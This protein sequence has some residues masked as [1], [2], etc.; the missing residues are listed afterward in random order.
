MSESKGISRRDFLKVGSVLGATAAVG[1]TRLLFPHEADAQT[2]LFSFMQRKYATIDEMYPI[3]ANYKRMDEKNIMFCRAAWDPPSGMPVG[4]FI[5]FLS[6]DSGMVHSPERGQPGYMP[7]DHAL[8]VAA[9]WGHDVGAP[10]SKGGARSSGIL[11]DWKVYAYPTGERYNFESKDEAARIV[12]RA[13]L[14]LGAD[15]VGI[16]PFD[17]R[18]VYSKWYDVRPFV[19]ERKPPIYEDAVFPFQPKTVIST[20]YEMDYDGI[21]A[22]GELADAA[23]GLEYT[24]MAEVSA[25]IAAFLNNLGYRAIPAGNDT[26]LSIPIAVQAGL[27][28]L[29]RMGTLITQKYG[30]RVRLAKVYTD[31]DMS[32]DRPTSFGVKE[33]CLRCKKCADLCPAGAISKKDQPTQESDTGTKSSNTGVLK[34][35]QNAEHCMAQWDRNGASCSVCLRV[36]PFNKLDTWNH[37]MA[38]TLATLPVG[39]DVARQLDDLFGYG[40][41]NP[42]ENAA[43]FWNKKG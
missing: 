20:A 17:E 23:V 8:H 38:R 40:K 34:W 15:L 16:A 19:D 31:L 2:E 43:Y 11:T 32:I 18:W 22:A 13:S 7:Y 9:W 41:A 29:G 10:M 30:G 28:E 35:Y 14:F 24:H 21:K 6:K 1:G 25:R 39:R 27:G 26:A 12:K 37:Q 4:Q 36:C 33:F 3:S 5:S 42:A